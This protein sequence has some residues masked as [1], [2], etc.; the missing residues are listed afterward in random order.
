MTSSSWKNRSVTPQP[1]PGSGPWSNDDTDLLAILEQS[2]E[3]GFLGPGPVVFHVEHAGGFGAILGEA[4]RVLD[5][6]SGGGVPGLV[7]ARAHPDVHFT[8]VDAMV[9][10]TTFL[11]WAAMSLGMADRVDVVTGRAEELAR[12]E[13]LAGSFDLVVTRS[14]GP[15]GVTAECAVGFLRPGGKLVVSEPPT[16]E[17]SRWPR[18]GLALLGLVAV[19]KVSSGSASLQV[20][21]LTGELDSRYPR[22]VGVPA[23][24]PLF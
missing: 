18:D 3:H 4:G 9:R 16:D 2:K 13:D 11:S 20:M 5:L 22:R 7:L 12:R 17:A 8:L 6:G 1:S 14:F 23:K 10:R 19:E 24:R 21:Q 15:P